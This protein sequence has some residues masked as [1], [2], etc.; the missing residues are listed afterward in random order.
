MADYD[1]AIVGAGPGGYVAA[2]RAAQLGLKTAL[3]ERAEVGGI[4][5]NWGCI[6][7]KALLYNAELVSILGRAG[8]FGISFDNL[9][10]D[11]GKAIDRSRRVV[12]RLT[13]GVE[14]MLKKNKVEMVQGE[15]VLKD[16]QTLEVKESGQRV[17]ARNIVLATGAQPRGLPMLQPDGDRVLTSR[18][19]LELR[20]LPASVVIVGGGAV[21]CEFAYLYNAYGATVTIV[22]LLPH[23]LPNEDEEISQHLERSFTKQGIQVLTGAQVKEATVGDGGV[24]VTV[25]SQGQEDQALTCERVLMAVG[26]HG[27][28]E[29]LGLEETGVQVEKGFI[30]VN[31]GMGTTVSGVYAIGDVTGEM[32]LAHVASAQGIMLMERLAGRETPPVDYGVMPRTTYCHPQVASFGLT[33]R[34]AEEQGYQVKVGKFPFIASG[35]ALAVGDTDGMVKV[36]ADARHGEL[37]GAHLIGGQVTELLPELSMAHLLEGTATEVGFLVHAHPSLAEVVKEAALAVNG[38]AIHI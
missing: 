19:A 33:E 9:R 6:P 8:E 10:L 31:K 5:L 17:A 12:Q 20:K 27:N 18:E 25:A 28:S 2:I 1:V 35:K 30:K 24:V 13:R 14:T 22:E 29:G 7:S 16:P 3:V 15:A 11:Y 38:E 4:C 23:L 21:G 32:P 37:L 36:V 34:Q 26:I